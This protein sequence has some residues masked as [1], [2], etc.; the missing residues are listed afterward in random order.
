MN[1]TLTYLN[2]SITF[3]CQL[4]NRCECFYRE[5]KIMAPSISSQLEIEEQNGKEIGFLNL[6]SGELKSIL[7]I[8][9]LDKKYR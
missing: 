3:F 1:E 2:V 9:T 5:L 7:L 6:S 4:S 8:N